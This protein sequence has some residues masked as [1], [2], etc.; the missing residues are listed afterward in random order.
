[1]K[2][3][4]IGI[5]AGCAADMMVGDPRRGHPV[6]GFGRLAA[7]V[8]RR[9]W[10]DSR[11][12]GSVH[13]G[14]LVAATALLAVAADRAAKRRPCARAAM[15]AALTWTVVGG[16]SLRREAAGIA[17]AIEHGDLDEARRRLPALCGR[18]PAHLSE[19]EVVR[20][21]VESVAENTSD[22]VVAPLWWGAMAGP[23]GLAAYRA[24]NTLDAMIGHKS[25]RYRRFGWAAARLDDAANWIPARCAAA[26]AVVLAPV[27]GGSPGSAARIWHRDGGAHPSPNAGQ[28]EAAF[29]GALDRTLGGGENRYP[30]HTDTRPAMGGGPA[31]N[32][33]DLRRAVRLSAAVS[34]AAAVCAA[35]TASRR[36][37]QRGKRAGRLR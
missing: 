35:A 18:D 23:A 15:A 11:L 5:L 28:V 34:A 26:L 7:D 24:V 22:A 37:P 27:V 29:A 8:E 36:R 31:P 12:A 1:M 2:A 13:T 33:A 19:T 20:A 10:R 32:A 9:T 3:W 21:A 4:G 25:P 30:G 14:T 6:A 16:H 17:A